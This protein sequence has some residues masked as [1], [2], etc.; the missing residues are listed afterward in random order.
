METQLGHGGA[1]GLII[2]PSLIGDDAA[3]LTLRILNGESPAN[4]PIVLGN[5]TKPM[6]D[7]RQL[8]RWGISES[9]LPSGSEIRFREP[10]IWEQYRWHVITALVI[11]ALQLALITWLLI[12]R[13]R[14]RMV[15]AKLLLRLA[16][17]AHLNRSA[18]AGA[19]SASIAHE[20]NQPLGAILSS[21]EAAE[22]YLN[23]S[24][25]NLD[26]VKTILDD[27]RRDDQHAADIISH[28]RGLLKKNGEND[29]QKVDLNAAI[30]DT[31]QII[32][33]EAIKRGVT[34]NTNFVEG[35]RSVRADKIQ[36]QQ[37]LLNLALNGMDAM[38]DC[39]PGT[40]KLS[41]GTALAGES[42]VE[43]SVSD[44][45]PGIPRDNLNKVFDTFYTTKTDGTGLGLS[46]SRTIIE[47][48]GGEMWAENQPE[49][50]A[51]FR[52]TLPLSD[53]PTL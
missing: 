30:N 52:F 42:E 34:L 4:I 18:T 2:R 31:V 41:I 40:R 39:I 45:G 10:G 16:E 38:A 13:R 11:I 1:G 19:L 43:V 33:P 6:F 51:I 22:L 23:A 53:R 48:S 29:L 12:E 3:R 27:I 49:G 47:N 21:A 9:Q 44:S 5:Y 7:W 37:V 26:Q 20:L 35:V 36:L 50:G 17:L 46:I 14:R 15:E 8:T 24:P 32:G 25:P 28:L